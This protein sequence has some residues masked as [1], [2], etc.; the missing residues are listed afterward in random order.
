MG[1]RTDNATR[2]GAGLS[3]E[4]FRLT[5]AQGRD[6][7]RKTFKGSTATKIVHYFLTGAPNPY[8][9]NENAVASG[10]IRRQILADLCRFWFGDKL[11]VAEAYDYRWNEQA[12]AYEIDTQFI[13]GRHAQ[14]HQPFSRPCLQL[15]DLYRK[16]L[17]PLKRHLKQSGFDGLLWQAGGGNPVA[18][19]N[20]MYMAESGNWAW[21]D[22]ESGVPA[23]IPINP[24]WLF[25][26]YLPKSFKHGEPLFD[27]V[28]VDK[29]DRYIRD[30]QGE[31]DQSLGEGSSAALVEK[32]E[33]LREKQTAWKSQKRYLRSIAY[34]LARKRIDTVQAQWYSKHPIEWYFR[35]AIHA[36]SRGPAVL[37]EKIGKLFGRIKALPFGKMAYGF[38]KF[39]TSQKYRTQTG[40]N[41]VAMRIDA[42][43][44]RGQLTDDQ[45]AELRA[46]L[47]SEDASVYI[48]DFAVHV[49]IKPIIKTFEWWVAP[50]LFAAGVI[51]KEML[52]L[53]IASGGSIGRT[54][55]TLYRLMRAFVKGRERPWVAL[56]VGLFPVVGNAAYPL[57]IVYSGIGK[58][59]FLAQFIVYDLFTAIG[60][61]F[62]IWGGPDTLTEHVFNH[63]PDWIL[64]KLDRTD[65]A[66]IETDAHGQPA[67]SLPSTSAE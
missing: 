55:Y 22:L 62:P 40:R 11:Q 29:L 33:Q 16:L 17:D 59:H 66:E 36:V 42:W 38:W 44:E 56:G 32:V 15:D 52:L 53:I 20:F 12:L 2:I 63:L 46:H 26:F 48:T 51:E 64:P 35:C 45:A 21:I 6:I 9:W 54:G 24:L 23:L 50:M 37:A 10:V 41:L 61:K 60:Q 58:G 19:N 67:V 34:Q 5:D 1:N 3:G 39:G 43:Q 65:T 14:L 4:V 7:A 25:G 13:S 18:A 27:D 57:Q 8:V 31:L 28:D 30:K 47:E 49:A